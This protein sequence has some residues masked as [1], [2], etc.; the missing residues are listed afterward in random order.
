MTP[1]YRIEGKQNNPIRKVNFREAH[2][3]PNDAF[4]LLQYYTLNLNI[5]NLEY[6]IGKNVIPA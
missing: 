1:E 4:K 2:G 5:F 3:Y 6:A